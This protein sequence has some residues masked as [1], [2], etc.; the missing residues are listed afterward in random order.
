MINIDFNQIAQKHPK[1]FSLFCVNCI[2]VNVLE[3]YVKFSNKIKDYINYAN[4]QLCY[5]DLEKFFM[6]YNILLF[7]ILKNLLRYRSQTEIIEIYKEFQLEAIY[8]AFEILEGKLNY[9]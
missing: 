1:A 4:E 9:N 2:D 3:I 7:W 8:R 5:C 6:G